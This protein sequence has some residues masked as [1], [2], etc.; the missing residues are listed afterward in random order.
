MQDVAGSQSASIMP[1]ET[2][3]HKRAAAA[4]IIADFQSPANGQIGSV[5]RPARRTDLQHRPGGERNG[6]P[7]GNGGVIKRRVHVRAG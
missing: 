7:A 1:A 2:T 6:L 4:Q 5:S 3:Q